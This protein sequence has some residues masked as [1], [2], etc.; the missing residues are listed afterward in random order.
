MKILYYTA[1]I[2]L[3][4]LDIILFGLMSAISIIPNTIFLR[5]LTLISGALIGLYILFK[6]R[7]IFSIKNSLPLLLLGLLFLWVLI[8]YIFISIDPSAQ[9]KELSSVWKRVFL[10]FIFAIGLGLLV[11]SMNRFGKILLLLGF[12]ATA[13]VFFFR[14]MIN[15]FGLEFGN[16]FFVI[17]YFDPGS[18]GYIPKYYFS[19]F[20]VPFIAIIYCSIARVLTWDGKHRIIFIFVA[21]VALFGC[22]YIFYVTQNKNGILYFLILTSIFLVYLLRKF[23][24]K[25]SIRS[26]LFL[27]IFAICTFS[28]IYLNIVSKPPWSR[29]VVD[30][31][32]ALDFGHNDQWKYSGA[33]GYPLNELGIPVSTTV[34][35]RVTWAIKGSELLINY[36]YGYGLVINSFGSLAKYKWPDSMLTHA[37]SGW[38]DL[39]LAFGFPGLFL[40]LSSLIIAT[41]NCLHKKNFIINSGAW[42]LP[43]ISL[44]FISAEVSERILLDYLIFLIAF[45]A[46]ASINVD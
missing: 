35:E 32:A 36:P 43:S 4:L 3:S 25:I 41:K 8:H 45:F 20:I 34:Y 31:R 19:T 6:N 1:P 13:A 38:I 23:H 2:W 21:G 29:Y 42:V 9:F 39:G 5:N 37:H 18:L 15:A 27:G 44:V 7:H 26:F 11:P 30:T 46:S 22:I 10:S 14:Q 16:R 24:T 12:A 40:L 28:T 17:N 33:K